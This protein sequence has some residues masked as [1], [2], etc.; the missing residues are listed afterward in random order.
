MHSPRV[1]TRRESERLDHPRD[2]RLGPYT[3]SNDKNAAASSWPAPGSRA[4][5]APRV[6]TNREPGEDRRRCRRPARAGEHARPTT[7]DPDPSPLPRESSDFRHC[8]T[9]RFRAGHRVTDSWTGIKLPWGELSSV[10]V[11]FQDLTD[12]TGQL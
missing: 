8:W 4:D 12:L 6:W 1:R 5:G 3:H 2:Q 10:T 11:A 9:G 7:P